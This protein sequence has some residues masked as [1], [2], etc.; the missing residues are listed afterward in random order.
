MRPSIT[1]LGRLFRLDWSNRWAFNIL[2]PRQNGCAFSWMKT[3]KCR[4][5]F[6]WSL[7]LR[8]QLTIFQHRFCNG[9]PG[10]KPLSEPMMVNILRHIC[11]SLLQWVRDIDIWKHLRIGYTLF[12][13]GM[14]YSTLLSAVEGRSVVVYATCVS[15]QAI[16]YN[17]F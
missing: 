13:H 2:R 14:I 10:V 17:T 4:L 9:R 15:K 3:Y 1:L 7:F 5:R 8:V 16:T 6:N 11:D 12:R